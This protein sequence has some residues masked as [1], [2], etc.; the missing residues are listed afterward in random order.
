MEN[1]Y[2][3]ISKAIRNACTNQYK[4]DVSEEYDSEKEIL[5]QGIIDV[6]FEEEDGIVLADY[7]TDHVKNSE[8]LIKRYEKQLQIYGESLE[9]MTGK[10]VK[11]RVIYSFCLG[12]EIFV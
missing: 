7:K 5:I 3:S 2:F 12:K 6:Y 8:E 11:E 1:K 9:Q 4:K 10:K